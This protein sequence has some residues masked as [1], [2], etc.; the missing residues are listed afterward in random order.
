MAEQAKETRVVSDVWD[1]T[2]YSWRVEADGLK[3][4]VDGLKEGKI[5]GRKCSRCNT[6]YVPGPCYCRKC[7]VDIDE[8]VEVEKTGR[9]VTFAVNLADI[10][11]NPLDEPVISIVAKLD[12]SDSLYPGILEGIDWHEVEAGMAVKLALREELTGQ[13]ADITGY[14]PA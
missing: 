11:G 4:L 7:F 2:T 1:L 10:R 9:I 13:L 6:V 14:V 5:L 8:V 3:L 12:G